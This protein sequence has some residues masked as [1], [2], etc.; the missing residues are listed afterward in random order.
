M[1]TPRSQDHRQPP[2]CQ[3][4]P[5]LMPS[6]LC[7]VPCAAQCSKIHSTVPPALQIIPIM[8]LGRRMM[9]FSESP[10]PHA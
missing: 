3:G 5:S 10:T 9:G 1:A 4:D 7:E 6:E 8:R 2:N